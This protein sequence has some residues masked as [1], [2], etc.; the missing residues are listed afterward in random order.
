MIKDSSEDIF[1]RLQDHV[2]MR[3]RILEVAKVSV[4][5]VQDY[6]N[7]VNVSGLKKKESFKLKVLTS[8]IES[9][10]DSLGLKLPE[11]EEEKKHVFI[12][13]I[14]EKPKVVEKD[15]LTLDLEEIQRKLDS[16]KL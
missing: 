12:G 1:V 8:E 3:S 6:E 9:L 16:L 7:L 13:K 11:F 15:E 14:M 10:L 5:L 4:E 2:G